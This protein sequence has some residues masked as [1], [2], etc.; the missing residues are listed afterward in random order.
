MYYTLIFPSYLAWHYG[1]AYR[2]IIRLWTNF[3]WFFGNFFSLTL[4]IKTFFAPWKRI[5]EGRGARFSL[6]NIA[7]AVVTNTVMRLVGA[8]MRS[9]V[10]LVGSIAVLAVFWLGILLIA[11]WT[12]LPLLLV[13]SFIYGLTVFIS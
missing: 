2:D 8:L 5:K 11:V 1:E 7:E 3:L 9:A 13:L 12:L 6:K 4:L 10:I